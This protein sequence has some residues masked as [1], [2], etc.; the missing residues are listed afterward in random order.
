MLRI[1][2]IGLWIGAVSLGSTYAGAYWKR[3]S[4]SPQTDQVK[5]KIEVKKVRPITAPVIAG[6]ALRGYVSAEFSYVLDNSAIGQDGLDI[7]SYFMDEAFKLIYSESN[8]DFDQLE[9]VDVDALTKKITAKVNERVG[10]HA[11]KETL[12]KNLAF[13]AKEDM[14]H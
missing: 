7:E 2:L 1:F 8:I 4:L 11:V 10:S 5:E 6:G 13:I 3:R 9:K 14:R 12:V